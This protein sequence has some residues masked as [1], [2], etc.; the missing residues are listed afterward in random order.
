MAKNKKQAASFSFAEFVEKLQQEK[1]TDKREIETIKERKYFL[2]V[3]EGERTEPNYF[4]A[5]KKKLPKEMLDTIEISGEGDNTIGVVS[6][7]I[8]YR[9]KRLDSVT[10]PPYDEVWAVF[11]RDS[12][13]AKRVNGAI[14]LAVQNNIHQGFSNEAFELWY[15]LHFQYLDTAISRNQYIDILNSIFTKNLGIR[16]EKND[17]NVYDYLEDIGDKELAKKYA[18]R[19][20]SIFTAE[21]PADSIPMTT[22]D[23]LVSS[24]DEYTE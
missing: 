8:E 4:N 10:L 5:Y 6:K 19:L 14:E 15:I 11:D 3:C 9:D 21:T 17:P 12:F 20:R 18:A 7:A 23:E 24:L 13:P 2:I 16:Y 22:I 1:P